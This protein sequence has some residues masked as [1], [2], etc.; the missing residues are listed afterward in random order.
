MRTRQLWGLLRAVRQGERSQQH[1]PSVPLPLPVAV[2]LPLCCFL[3]SPLQY[4][5]VLPESPHTVPFPT[6]EPQSPSHTDFIVHLLFSPPLWGNLREK[7][8]VSFLLATGRKSH[9]RSISWPMVLPLGLS[10]CCAPRLDCLSSPD[11]IRAL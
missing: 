9:N 4:Y 10:P 5:I 1:C 11:H 2:P 3:E 7:Q 6:P 8:E